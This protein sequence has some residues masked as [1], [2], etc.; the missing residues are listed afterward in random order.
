VRFARLA[1]LSY[2]CAD[3]QLR[4]TRQIRGDP[5][6]V[7]RRFACDYAAMQ[8]TSARLLT[9]PFGSHGGDVTI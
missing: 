2:T 5:D 4:F 1:A 3:C 7:S 9:V 8:Q 6:L